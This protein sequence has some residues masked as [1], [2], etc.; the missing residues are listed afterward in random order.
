ME[1][2]NKFGERL[3]KLREERNE[4]QQQLADAIGIT[5]QS[6]SRYETNERTPNID[7]IYNV[8][9][10]YNVSADYLLGLADVQSLDNDI[11]TAC[12][13]TGLSEDVIK[14]LIWLEE[15]RTLICGNGNGIKSTD[16]INDMF[17][18]QHFVEVIKCLASYSIRTKST[19]SEIIGDGSENFDFDKIV[20]DISYAKLDFFEANQAFSKMAECFKNPTFNSAVNIINKY[21]RPIF[22]NGIPQMPLSQPIDTTDSE[23]MEKYEQICKQYAD[24]M[25]RLRNEFEKEVSENGEHN[26]ETE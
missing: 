23:A 4:T 19:V 17:L 14:K 21:Y 25:N 18:N 7:L 22:I 8:S 13:V 5:R 11:K 9:K 2:V 15:T 24:D 26:P 20:Q 10:H 1:N 3:L 12:K 16:I 6:L